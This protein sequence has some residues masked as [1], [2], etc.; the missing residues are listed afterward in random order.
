[1]SIRNRSLLKLAQRKREGHL[2]APGG[3]SWSLITGTSVWPVRAGSCQAF[4]EELPLK[5]RLGSYNNNLDTVPRVKIVFA[6]IL[7]SHKVYENIGG[8][9]VS[10]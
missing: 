6:K 8:L 10:G 1:M 5:W 7:I 4:T 9:F 3:T 2:K